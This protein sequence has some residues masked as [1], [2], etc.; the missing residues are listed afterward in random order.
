[1]YSTRHSPRTSRLVGPGAP[2]SA[3]TTPA[4]V[5]TRL[6]SCVPRSAPWPR[7]MAAGSSGT[8]GEGSSPLLL[9]RPATSSRTGRSIANTALT[10]VRP[11][12]LRLGWNLLRNLL[13]VVGSSPP[14][15][16]P[17]SRSALRVD[18][19]SVGPVAPRS[20]ECRSVHLGRSREPTPRGSST[21]SLRSSA[22]SDTSW[23]MPSARHPRTS[24]P[25][26]NPLAARQRG[27]RSRAP[28]VG[29]ASPRRRRPLSAFA[30]ARE[31]GARRVLTGTPPGGMVT[32][33][34]AAVPRRRRA[35][36]NPSG[37]SSAW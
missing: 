28:T 5:P 1:M 4:T 19:A 27:D 29:R 24:K 33:R 21:P 20:V 9:V 32:N 34:F 31:Q 22:Q 18:R 23:V 36:R 16:V 17:P 12:T 35:R 10:S 7:P 2:W 6:T 15:L 8:P 30:R 37:R 26:P 3:R 11:S 14:T 25:R 13:R